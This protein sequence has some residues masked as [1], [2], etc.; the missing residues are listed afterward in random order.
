[1]R[2]CLNCYFC[3]IVHA[4]GGWRFS[5]CYANPYK[6][7][8]TAEIKAC[9]LTLEEMKKAQRQKAETQTNNLVF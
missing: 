4:T 2:D 6:G 8:W 1:M 7:K 5:G 3:K 9:P